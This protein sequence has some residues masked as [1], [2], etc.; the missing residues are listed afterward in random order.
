MPLETP[1]SQQS[2]FQYIMDSK[3]GTHTTI[4]GKD[5]LYFAGTG[6]FQLQSH[7]A[8]IQAAVDAT[9]K[10]GIGSATSRSITGT[11]NLLLELEQKIADFFGTEDAA[12]LPSGYLSNM[13]GF[14]V[15]ERLDVFDII[16]IDES[17]HYS[18]T[19]GAL[20][21]GKKVIKFKHLDPNDLRGKIKK[22]SKN[23]EK[24]LIA[25]DGLF[26]IWAELAPVVDYLKI[27]E[28]F[29]GA[30]WVD[31][32]HGVGI[33]GENGRGIYEYFHLNSER[34]FMGATLSKAFGAYGGFVTGNFQFINILKSGDVMTGTSSPPH[35][36]VSAAL[37]GLELVNNNPELRRR[38]W[39][40][41]IYLK[42]K[43]KDLGIAVSDNYLPIVTFVTGNSKKMQNIQHLLMNKGIYIQFVKYRGSG[44]D[45]VLR[46]VITSEHTKEEIDFLVSALGRLL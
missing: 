31:D 32:A 17:A 36:M 18:N 9:M 44:V 33:L 1:V 39:D 19:S 16:F 35:A 4:N 14:K 6:Y 28:E 7:P 5:Y 38:L 45:G 11:T 29:N 42:N 24:P 23:G 8:M 41:A 26:P 13:A 15:L 43:I 10:F 30:V 22:Y 20:G 46:I 25:S 40:N 3:V 12:Y 27:A 21:I 2:T 34:L 37:K